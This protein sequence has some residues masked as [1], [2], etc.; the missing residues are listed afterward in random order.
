MDNIEDLVKERVSNQE[1]AELI[2]NYLKD[3]LGTG[4]KLKVIFNDLAE[5]DD[6]LNEFIEYLKKDTYDL[7]N[8]VSVSGYTAKMIHEKDA[9]LKPTGVYTYL[10]FLRD[11][12]KKALDYLKNG[13]PRK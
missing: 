10:T 8:P 1:D 6:I 13:F 11:D 9:F 2:I 12:P 7:S 3:N 5:Y 4:S